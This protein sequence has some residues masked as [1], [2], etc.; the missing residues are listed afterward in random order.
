MMQFVLG[1]IDSYVK[2]F[3]VPGAVKVTIQRME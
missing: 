1:K 2:A 3:N